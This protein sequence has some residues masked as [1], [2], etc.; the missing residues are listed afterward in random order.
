MIDWDAIWSDYRASGATILEGPLTDWEDDEHIVAAAELLE[1]IQRKGGEID[2]NGEI[3][4][5]PY[6]EPLVEEDVD[7]WRRVWPHARELLAFERQLSHD[8]AAVT[9][10]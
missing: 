4:L 10:G 6:A 1:V 3:R 9:C 5:P 7:R 8:L 2:A